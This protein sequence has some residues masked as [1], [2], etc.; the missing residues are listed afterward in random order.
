M[1]V[2]LSSLIEEDDDPAQKF[3]KPLVIEQVAYEKIIP[4]YW[5]LVCMVARSEQIIPHDAEVVVI[6]EFVLAIIALI[7]ELDSVH[8]CELIIKP[9]SAVLIVDPL[10]PIIKLPE[11]PDISDSW[12]ATILQKLIPP[13]I[14]DDKDDNTDE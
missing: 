1:A 14:D 7:V 6:C 3:A 12:D 2:P 9:V 5:A 8:V 10:E 13:V 4:L 11:L